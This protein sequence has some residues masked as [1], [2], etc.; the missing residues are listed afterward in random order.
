DAFDGERHLGDCR[1]GGGTA[2]R[3]RRGAV[4]GRRCRGARPAAI[5]TLVLGWRRDGAARTGQGEPGLPRAGRGA[6]RG[7]TRGAAGRGAAGEQRV[8]LS[9]LGR[10]PQRQRGG[11]APLCC[12]YRGTRRELTLS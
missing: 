7:A 11:A 12:H 1:G 6:A 4:E 3:A 5:A 9:L 2:A 8:L 10:E